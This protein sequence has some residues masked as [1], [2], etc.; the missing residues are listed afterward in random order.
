MIK[1]NNN[2]K[3]YRIQNHLSQSKIAKMVGINETH[4]QKIEY[5]SI[6]PSVKVAILIAQVLHTEVENLFFLPVAATTEE[7][8]P[9]HNR[10][11]K[12]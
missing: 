8:K 4:Y 1:I 5:G 12:N 7:E 3:Q 6:S 10:V 9:N 11:N 2:L